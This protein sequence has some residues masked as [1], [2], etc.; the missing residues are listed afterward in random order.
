MVEQYGV[1]FKL[2]N[3]A[4]RDQVQ[5][6]LNDMKADGTFQSLAEKWNLTDSVIE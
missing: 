6:T 3:E 5:E 1:G 2:G 4:L